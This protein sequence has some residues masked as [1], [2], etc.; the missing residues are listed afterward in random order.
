MYF[1]LKEKQACY[2]K[3]GIKPHLKACQEC[4]QTGPTSAWWSSWDSKSCVDTILLSPDDV[5]RFKSL[6]LLETF[7]WRHRFTAFSAPFE[8]NYNELPLDLLIWQN[9]PEGS[10][11]PLQR[12]LMA[13]DFSKF[14]TFMKTLSV[15]GGNPDEKTFLF[16]FVSAFPEVVCLF[17]NLFWSYSFSRELCTVEWFHHPQVLGV[18]LFWLFHCTCICLDRVRG[19]NLEYKPVWCRICLW[20]LAF[21][22]QDTNPPNPLEL[23]QWS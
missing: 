5:F 13:K 14:P 11:L 1:K 20:E 8:R 7:L 19:S 4:L 12:K 21:H 2:L 16:K 15:E 23:S 22:I 10:K 17:T 18:F 3:V 6:S 9:N